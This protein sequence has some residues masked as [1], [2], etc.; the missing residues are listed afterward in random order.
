MEINEVDIRWAPLRW[1]ITIRS[2]LKWLEGYM[3]AIPIL[4][5]FLGGLI[6]DKKQQ[7]KIMRPPEKVLPTSSTHL[8]NL[9]PLTS[10]VNIS[11]TAGGL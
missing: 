3:R 9:P 11:V 6:S 2:M 7:K 4:L 8:L 1:Q 5:S 10:E